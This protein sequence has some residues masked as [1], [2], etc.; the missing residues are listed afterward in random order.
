[1]ADDGLHSAGGVEGHRPGE[2]RAVTH[3]GG[4]P[5]EQFLLDQ[6][7][8]DRSPQKHKML[9]PAGEQPAQPRQVGFGVQGEA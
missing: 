8:A 3:V 6:V 4:V 7:V 5:P 9:R 2:L 1:M